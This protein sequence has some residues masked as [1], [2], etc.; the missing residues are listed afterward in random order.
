MS[1]F[2][3]SAIKGKYGR[4]AELEDRLGEE[5]KMIDWEKLGL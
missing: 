5:E 1:K 4:I 2:I 3:N